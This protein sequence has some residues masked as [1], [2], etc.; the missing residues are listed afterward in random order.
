[1]ARRAGDA[2]EPAADRWIVLK[3]E[4]ALVRDMGV[5]IKGDVRER[6]LVTDEKR[7]LREVS[8]HRRECPVTGQVALL[9]PIRKLISTARIGK[10]PAGD[11]DCGFVV[12]LLEEHPLQ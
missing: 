9:Q 12:V 6:H 1:M 5:R 4:T 10:P 11:G 2:V 3:A 7:V 8:L